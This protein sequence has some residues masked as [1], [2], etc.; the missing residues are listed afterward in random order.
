[1]QEHAKGIIR[2]M[3]A[4]LEDTVAYS[5]RLGDHLVPANELVEKQ[6]RLEFTGAIFCVN[7]GRKS[8]KSFNQG[9]CFPCFQKLAACD[10]CIIHPERCH[11]DQGTCRE[12]AWG[13]QFCMQDHI[14]YLANSSG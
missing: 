5:L 12:P 8:S 14:V 3:S 11:F 4:R 7:C 10:S 2:K 6:V 13:E 1:M 9:F